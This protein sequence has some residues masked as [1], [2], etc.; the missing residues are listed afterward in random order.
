MVSFGDDRNDDT[1][2]MVD[3]DERAAGGG[4]WIDSLHLAGNA[5]EIGDVFVTDLIRD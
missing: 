3:D 4:G 1:I 2:H 5:V